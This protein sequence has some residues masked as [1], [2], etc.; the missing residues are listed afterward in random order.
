[1]SLKLVSASSILDFSLQN[2]FV[3]KLKDKIMCSIK[4]DTHTI[5]KTHNCVEMTKIIYV[6]TNNKIAYLGICNH[7]IASI[8][9]EEVKSFEH[10]IS[11]KP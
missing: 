8:E 1:M 5:N 11:K 4:L 7:F 10:L 6:L 2:I 3:E 9:V